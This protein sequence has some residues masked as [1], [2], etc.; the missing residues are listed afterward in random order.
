[1][2]I[3]KINFQLKSAELTPSGIIMEND[4]YI[5]I[6]NPRDTPVDLCGYTLISG[7]GIENKISNGQKF[8]FTEQMIIPAKNTIKIYT[9]KKNPKAAR[10][11]YSLRLNKSIWNNR[12][13]YA[14]LLNQNNEQVYKLRYPSSAG[15]TQND[16]AAIDPVSITI[17]CQ[18]I[19]ATWGLTQIAEKVVK[20]ISPSMPPQVPPPNVYV[21]D[22][23]TFN[24]VFEPQVNDANETFLN[25]SFG[26]ADA[27]RA[28][29]AGLATGVTEKDYRSFGDSILELPN[30][31][32]FADLNVPDFKFGVSINED[33]MNTP[34]PATAKI[35]S[36]GGSSIDFGSGVLW[37]SGKHQGAAVKNFNSAIRS[38]EQHSIQH[39]NFVSLSS[40]SFS[41]LI[42]TSV[43]YSGGG[44]GVDA[45]FATKYS[46]GKKVDDQSLYFYVGQVIGRNIE[47]IDD[48]ELI[49]I[50]MT[51][52]ALNI[53]I[54]QG[55]QKYIDLYGSHFM[56][57]KI[58]GGVF[59]GSNLVKT[60]SEEEKRSLEIDAS[61]SISQ[62]GS[63]QDVT[64]QFTS[65]MEKS[66]VSKTVSTEYDATGAPLSD[67]ADLFQLAQDHKNAIYKAS[68]PSTLADVTYFVTQYSQLYQVQQ[69]IQGNKVIKENGEW[70]TIST[71]TPNPDM[72]LLTQ[73]ASMELIDQIYSEITQLTYLNNTVATILS[74]Q[75]LGSNPFIDGANIQ[76]P[77]VHYARKWQG[78]KI[79][80]VAKQASAAL[81]K[82]QEI[83]YT[84]IS[85]LTIEQ[86]QQEYVRSPELSAQLSQLTSKLLELKWRTEVLPPQ[87]TKDP[88]EGALT[89]SVGNDTRV[90]TS[91]GDGGVFAV[92]SL[93]ADGPRANVNW[94]HH[95]NY[96]ADP[97]SWIQV[98]ETDFDQPSEPKAINQFSKMINRHVTLW[99]WVK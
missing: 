87:T 24:V 99:V 79:E 41:S 11:E 74:E 83:S 5:E 8:V 77:T 51:E 9:K 4:E 93:I 53:L 94:D 89:A 58:K 54:T 22:K 42:N 96:F 26:P 82:V 27:L 81:A 73:T 85:M 1:M 97:V 12:A 44:Y 29:S 60:H 70:K 2:L 17:A 15:A 56:T 16:A 98:Y 86:F 75:P 63:G 38:Q 7:A 68:D 59:C 64:S 55:A 72:S 80:D 49:N 36:S 91:S 28:T 10:G 45:S 6:L 52:E 23:A 95:H 39:N 3:S 84:N 92:V 69:A 46:L 40:D 66:H 25:Y 65:D 43:N 47:K 50:E 62:W 14:L 88:R 78:P 34:L 35:G 30:I 21:I 33:I 90:S 76:D 71:F 13:D 20:W 18:V 19:G 67:S 32:A 37:P 61:V 31:P 48:T 57:G